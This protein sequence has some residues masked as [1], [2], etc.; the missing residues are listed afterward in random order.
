MGHSVTTLKVNTIEPAGSTLTLGASGDSVVLADDV[1]S[2]TYK[3]AGGNTLFTSDGSGNLSSVNSGFGDSIKLLS[4]A[5][6]SN[7]ASI[8]FTLPTAYKQVKF[9]F[10]NVTAATDNI[11]FSFQVNAD[12]QSGFNETMTTTFFRTYIHEGGVYGAGMGYQTTFDQAQGTSYQFLTYDQG[13]AADE[14]AAGELH[15]FNP[16]STTYVK[17]FYSRISYSHHSEHMHEAY[18]AGYINTTTNLSEISFKFASGNISSGTIKM[19]GIS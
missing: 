5:T 8:S 10:Y 9:G 11:D 16:S 18:V 1:K 17:H 14:S 6:A 19:Y 12:G 15:L 13:N 7:S 3:D 4:T 2:N